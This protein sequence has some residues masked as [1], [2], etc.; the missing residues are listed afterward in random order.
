[1][2]QYGYTALLWAC[3]RGY[4]E[5]VQLLLQNGAD[6][7]AESV[8]YTFLNLCVFSTNFVV[9]KL[10]TLSTI[11]IEIFTCEIFICVF[12]LGHILLFTVVL[13]T[14]NEQM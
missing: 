10:Y 4:L 1:M 5:V 9:L 13:I 12:I 6:P 14:N 2:L 11:E 7:K 8:R 3:E